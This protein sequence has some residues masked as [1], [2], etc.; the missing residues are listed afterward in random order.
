[1]SLLPARRLFNFRDFPL[2][3]DF[4]G[5]QKKNSRKS[6]AKVWLFEDSEF[7][8]LFLLLLF[9]YFHKQAR[10]TNSLPTLEPP[11]MGAV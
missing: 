11:T 8:F 6:A 3:A 7:S 10:D 2:L 4:R 1:L 5:L 9:P